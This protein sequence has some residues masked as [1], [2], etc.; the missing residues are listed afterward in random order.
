MHPLARTHCREGLARKTSNV[1]VMIW[2][3]FRP[4]PGN[5]LEKLARPSGPRVT[6]ANDM[7]A[8]LVDLAGRSHLVFARQA[9]PV[10]H[11]GQRF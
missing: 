3:L 8:V 1:E 5:V 4:P 6:K 9:K 10:Q 7:A 2:K 11:V